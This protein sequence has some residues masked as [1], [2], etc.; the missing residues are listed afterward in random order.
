[1]E[2][3]KTELAEI[4]SIELDLLNEFARICNKHKLSYVLAGGT[5]LGAIR[6]KGFIPW[7]DDIDV[8]MT[9]EDYDRF[10]EVAEDDLDSAK[11]VFQSMDTEPNCG[12][13]FGKL[14]KKGTILSEE[15]SNHINMSQ[16]VWIDIFP[17][18]RVPNDAN[19][20]ARYLR[21]ISLLRNLYITKCGYKMPEGKSTVVTCAY[22]FAK[23]F[24]CVIPSS[25]LI[26]ILNKKMRQYAND[27]N[28]QLVYPFGG[29]YGEEVELIPRTMVTATTNVAFE[30]SQYLTFSDYDTYLT[31]HYGNYMELPPVEKRVG[32]VH[33][34]HEFK[35]R[36]N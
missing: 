4:K 9:R 11:Y 3:S 22:Y 20:R 21:E 30:G 31:K 16:G 23:A 12:L 2:L 25:W 5:C 33:H 36:M 13:V 35:S 18:D 15:Y 26:G 24:C 27:S 8:S 17:Y 19:R 34:L 7:D 29:A 6:H 1:M 10:A 28:C 14:R 32:G